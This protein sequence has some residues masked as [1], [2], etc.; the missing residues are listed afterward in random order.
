MKSNR[1]KKTGKRTAAKINRFVLALSFAAIVCFAVALAV[2]NIP[3]AEPGR[4]AAVPAVSDGELCVTVIDV[5]QGDSILIAFGNED[6]MLIDAGE[7]KDAQAVKETLDARD[8]TQID[9]LVATHP[10]ADHIG[11]IAEIIGTYEIGC[12]YMPDMQSDSKTFKNLMD[13]ID[14]HHIIVNNAYAGEAFELGNADCV[15]VSPEASADKDAN[16]ESVMLMLDYLDTEFLFTGDAEA[17]AE[18]EVLKAGYNIDADV[19][20]AAHHGSSTGT[21]EAFLKAVSPDFAVI[22]CGKDNDYGHPHK[23]TLDLLD[24]YGVDALRTDISGDVL[25]ISDGHNLKTVVGGL[26]A[27]KNGG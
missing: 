17:W 22:S 20:K 18:N 11:G 19:L 8:I 4:S 5:G 26:F 13:T 3:T 21:S 12:I 23:D 2:I 7:D 27:A 16:N 1:S 14:T 6:V 9:V 24:E 15:I 25:F 10:H